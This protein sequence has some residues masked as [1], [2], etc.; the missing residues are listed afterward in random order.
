MGV[1][2]KEGFSSFPLYQGHHFETGGKWQIHSSPAV[3]TFDVKLSGVKR[4]CL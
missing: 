4:Q 2:E 1:G 3:G